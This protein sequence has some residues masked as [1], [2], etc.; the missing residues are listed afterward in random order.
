MENKKYDAVLKKAYKKIIETVELLP[1]NGWNKNNSDEQQGITN[2]I[3]SDE[4]TG[5]TVCRGEGILDYPAEY[6]Y[7]F[8]SNPMNK[9]KYSKRVSCMEMLQK[10]HEG[11]FITY[12]TVRSP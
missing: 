12:N 8:L 10:S 5:M 2:H 11:N 3:R 9:P 4:E 6:L 1:E 7:K